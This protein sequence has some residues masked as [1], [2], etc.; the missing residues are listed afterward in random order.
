MSKW[1]RKGDK[2]VVVSGNDKG[3]VGAT[4]F[5]GI[6]GPSDQI[7]EVYQ[8]SKHYFAPG[9][10]YLGTN[11]DGTLKEG[12][13]PLKN[14]TMYQ[15]YNVLER[16][17]INAQSKIAY[18][19]SQKIS[20]N[21]AYQEALNNQANFEAQ[22]ITDNTDPASGST[23]EIIDTQIEDFEESKEALSNQWIDDAF[24]KDPL[25]G[26]HKDGID[27]KAWDRI[28]DD[29][30]ADFLEQN[31]IDKDWSEISKIEPND[32]SDTINPDDVYDPSDK[33]KLLLVMQRYSHMYNINPTENETVTNYI[34]RLSEVV[35]KNSKIGRA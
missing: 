16:D 1:I 15:T 23:N 20:T 12:W 2:V 5:N 19:E 9:S 24:G 31:K 10:E 17:Y 21:I 7:T 14:T 30:V 27:T 34:D 11:P 29:T 35:I 28:K 18:W 8:G 25:F 26:G 4:D 22:D 13:Q 33:E 32:F 6:K 3:K